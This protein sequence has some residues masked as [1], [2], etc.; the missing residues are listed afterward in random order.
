MTSDA[1]RHELSRIKALVDALRSS[2]PVAD[3]DIDDIRWLREQRR[4]L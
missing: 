3:E 2:F 4:Y 1:V